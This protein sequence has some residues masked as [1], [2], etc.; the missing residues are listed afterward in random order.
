[1]HTDQM[2]TTGTPG[3]YSSYFERPVSVLNVSPPVLVIL[4]DFSSSQ[5]DMKRNLELCS[6]RDLFSSMPYFGPKLVFDLRKCS[7]AHITF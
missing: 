7:R 6:N 3:Y 1:M 4:S 5:K 2:E